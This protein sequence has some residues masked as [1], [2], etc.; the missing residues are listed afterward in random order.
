MIHFN[1]ILDDE[2]FEQLSRHWVTYDPQGW[3]ELV[4][5]EITKE[6]D[7]KIIELAKELQGTANQMAIAVVSGARAKNLNIQQMSGSYGQITVGGNRL[8]SGCKI[9]RLLSHFS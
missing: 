3:M 9:G 7:D 4:V 5:A 2:Y 1:S 6:F 8:M